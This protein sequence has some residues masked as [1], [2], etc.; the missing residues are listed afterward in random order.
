M[1][2]AAAGTVRPVADL[3]RRYRQARHRHGGPEVGAGQQA[4]LLRERHRIEQFIE[5]AVLS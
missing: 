1:T 2:T 3:D 4:D 5:V